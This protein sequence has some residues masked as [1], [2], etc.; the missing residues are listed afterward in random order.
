[1]G[2]NPLK[3]IGHAFEKSM[4]LVTTGSTEKNLNDV[5]KNIERLPADMG[6]AIT[7]QKA[8]DRAEKLAKE[9]QERVRKELELL[10][11]NNEKEKKWS[12]R[13]LRNAGMIEGTQTGANSVVNSADGSGLQ[14]LDE[15]DIE[16]EDKLKKTIRRA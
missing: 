3:Q 15:T 14:N 8:K 12:D 5:W 11:E 9:E 4:N 13:Q 6:D 2:G 10:T 1:M 7:G 16:D